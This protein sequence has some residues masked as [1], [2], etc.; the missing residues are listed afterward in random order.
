MGDVIYLPRQNDVKIMDS[1]GLVVAIHPDGTM[2]LG[3]GILADYAARRIWEQVERAVGRFWKTT[4]VP[5]L[6]KRVASLE[7]KLDALDPEWRS[8]ESD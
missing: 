5:V 7:A 4:T 2:K 8:R 3:H 6:Q 1:K